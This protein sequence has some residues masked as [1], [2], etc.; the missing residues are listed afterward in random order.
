MTPTFTLQ[1]PVCEQ[2]DAFT[3]SARWTP[4]SIEVVLLNKAC[5]CTPATAQQK[6]RRQASTLP[7]TN[8]VPQTKGS[9]AH[10]RDR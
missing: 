4:A 8:N 3:Y 2:S 1:C 9:Y 7:W 5:R 6:V 10:E